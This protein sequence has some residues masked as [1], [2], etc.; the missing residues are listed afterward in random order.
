MNF[1]SILKSS[2]LLAT[3]LILSNCKK[4]SDSDA[5]ASEL[6]TTGS[7]IGAAATLTFD[8]I[9]TPVDLW[10][11]QYEDCQKDDVTTFKTTGKAV[12][13]DGATKCNADDPQTTEVNYTLSGDGKTLTVTDPTDGT[14]QVFTVKTLTT[15]KLVMTTSQPAEPDLGLPASTIELTYVPN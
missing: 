12:T 5:S 15:S 14:T 7:W 11:T 2:L 8:G 10:A 3:V 1:Q 4:D 6:L 13:D 9:P